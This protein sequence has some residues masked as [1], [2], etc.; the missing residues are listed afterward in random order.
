MLAFPKLDVDD[1]QC[2]LVE[3]RS[4]HAACCLIADTRLLTCRSASRTSS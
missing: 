2:F 4:V 1:S 3:V